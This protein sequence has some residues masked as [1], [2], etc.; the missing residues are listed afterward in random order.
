MAPPAA[1]NPG[2]AAAEMADAKHRSNE[3]C[4]DGHPANCAENEP[5]RHR[6][7]EPGHVRC[8][9]A[10]RSPKDQP[11]SGDDRKKRDDDKDNDRKHELIERAPPFLLQQ[12]SVLSYRHDALRSPVMP[13]FAFPCDADLGSG[14]AR[15]CLL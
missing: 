6:S 13:A 8:L 12:P 7:D 1:S 5:E 3:N 11:K 14:S 2:S 10:R 15:Y 4:D 9:V